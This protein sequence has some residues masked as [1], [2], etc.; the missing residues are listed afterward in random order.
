LFSEIVGFKV[1][2][3]LQTS[4]AREI[5]KKQSYSALFQP[6]KDRLTSFSHTNADMFLLCRYSLTDIRNLLDNIQNNST[7][8]K[9]IYLYFHNTEENKKVC[10]FIKKEYPSVLFLPYDNDGNKSL[11][12]RLLDCLSICKR[13]HI[14]IMADT[15]S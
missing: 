7:G 1:D 14:C 11:K 9:T 2:R 8:L 10:R 3:S 5:R 12:N 4:S 6:K 15:S 13:D